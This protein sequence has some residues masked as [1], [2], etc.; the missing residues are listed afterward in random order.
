MVSASHHF[1]LRHIHKA[2]AVDLMVI[3]HDLNRGKSGI[4]S[5]CKGTMGFHIKRMG[6]E[7]SFSGLYI[8]EGFSHFFKG[9][10]LVDLTAPLKLPAVGHLNNISLFTP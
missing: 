10:V 3:H 2:V 9:N 6:Q 4:Y 8:V 7:N 1:A 5:E